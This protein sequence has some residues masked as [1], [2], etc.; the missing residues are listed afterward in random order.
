MSTSSQTF[1]PTSLMKKRVAAT[2]GSKFMRKGLRS[3]Q[4]KVSWQRVPAVV[5]PATLQ[6]AVPAPWKGLP[7]GMPPVSVMRRILPI[8]TWRSREA[9]LAPAQPL[10]PA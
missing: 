5:L 6:R 3:P 4:A 7:A 8:I 10:S 9:S 2:L 1:W